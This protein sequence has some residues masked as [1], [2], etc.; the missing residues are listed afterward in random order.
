MANKFLLAIL[1]IIL[2]GTV[3]VAQNT[4]SQA[5]YEKWVD[6][7]NCKYIIAFVDK[8][9][10]QKSGEIN[11]KYKKDYTNNESKLNVNS[12]DEAPKYGEIKKVIGNFQKAKT[13]SEYINDKKSS[14]QQD[15]NK[16]QLINYLV[17]L[18][19]EQP[20]PDGNGFKG[21]LSNEANILKKDLQKQISDSLFVAKE[22]QEKVEQPQKDIKQMVEQN[23]PETQQVIDNNTKTKTEQS[24]RSGNSFW[25]WFVWFCIIAVTFILIYRFRNEVKKWLK[26]KFGSQITNK[27]TLPEEKDEKTTSSKDLEIEN[28]RLFQNLKQWENDNAKLN[29]E[30]QQLKNK[31]IEFQQQ[32]NELKNK[33]QLISE[34][35]PKIES[36]KETQEI[37]KS[38]K[39]YAAN[40]I[41]GIFNKIAELPNDYSVFELTILS[42]NIASFTV[43]RNAY[44]RVLVAP[45][46]IEGCDKQMLSNSPSNLDIEAGEARFHIESEKW[47]VIKKAKIKFI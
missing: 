14:L 15:W 34:V 26:H 45:E 39:L 10:T 41:D 24:A 44:D 5:E 46:F 35:F 4:V 18:P 23:T 32:I 33:E 21:Y 28:K 20:S 6:Y 1:C 12:F 11:D 42:Q 8:K 13:L 36:N 47:Q 27:N 40:I 37:R 31:I 9:I 43:Y 22:K 30:N 2:C 17:D 19:S 25:A 29:T 3:C 7:V 38:N 16:N